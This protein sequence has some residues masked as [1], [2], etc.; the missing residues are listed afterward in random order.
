MR[1]STHMSTED[2]VS[3]LSRTQKNTVRKVEK[4]RATEINSTTDTKMVVLEAIEE[5]VPVAVL[6]DI[7][8]VSVQR[9]YQI[10]DEARRLQ[11]E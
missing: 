2:R 1:T 8:K 5:G 6:A 3:A 7:L 10:R 9:I 11:V 4:A